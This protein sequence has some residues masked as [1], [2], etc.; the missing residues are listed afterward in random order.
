MFKLSATEGVHDNRVIDYLKNQQQLQDG[1]D[2][3]RKPDGM[4]MVDYS[5]PDM[6]IENFRYIT[7][8]LKRNG[9]NL[10]LV[11]SQLT[12]R[13]IMKLVDLITEAPTLEEINKPRWLT[14]LKDMVDEWGEKT[15]NDDQHKWEQYILDVEAL[16]E[17]WE[18]AL[19]D[20]EIKRNK[21]ASDMKNPD[22]ALEDLSE[23]KLR[24]LIRKTLRK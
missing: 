16:I 23:Q 15:Y 24:S 21:D 9:V 18:T 20:E 22:A 14:A 4:G 2:F 6:D 1:E 13:K 8:E 12:E 5:F 19:D 7:I 3:I 10:D 17:T 11:D